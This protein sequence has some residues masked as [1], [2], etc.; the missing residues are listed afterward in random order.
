MMVSALKFQAREHPVSLERL[1]VYQ[2]TWLSRGRAF[3]KRVIRPSNELIS[4]LIVIRVKRSF[5]SLE[6]VF[7]YFKTLSSVNLQLNFTYA[8]A[9]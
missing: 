3:Q 4:K 5:N 9:Y 6:V 8:N 1:A 2:P 7:T